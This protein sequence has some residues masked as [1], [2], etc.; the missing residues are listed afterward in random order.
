VFCELNWVA[1]ILEGLLPD[2]KLSP[3]H[4]HMKV[5]NTD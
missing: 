4:D 5:V 1:V 2:C 3:T